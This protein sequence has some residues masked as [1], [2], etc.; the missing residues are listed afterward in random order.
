[1]RIAIITTGDELIRGEI[2]DTNSGWLSGELFDMGIPPALHQTVGDNA[3][4]IRAAITSLSRDFDV[5]VFCGGLGPTPDDLT[6]DA[7]AA[8]LGVDIEVHDESLRRAQAFFESRNM[9]F[10]ENNFRQVRVPSGAE[11]YVNPVGLAPGFAVTLNACRLYFLPGPP[12][13]F[14]ALCR[15]FLLPQLKTMAE[16]Q[17]IATPA[18]RRFIIAGVPESHLMQRA[19]AI[20]EPFPGVQVGDR[21][22]YPEIWLKVLATG[23]DAESVLE[24][25]SRGVRDE[26]GASLVGEGDDTLAGVTGRLLAAR[27]MTLATA[28]SCTGGLVGGMITAVPGSS[29]WYNGGVVT[30]SNELKQHLLG[31]SP[32]LLETHGA[33]SEEVARSMAREA[34]RCCGA[35]IAVAVTGIAGPDGGSAEKPVGLV[36]FALAADDGV[37]HL[38]RVFRPGRGAVRQAAAYT[39]VDMVR[40][41]LLAIG[42]AK[43]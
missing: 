38:R 42:P 43:S 33:V 1:M 32:Q 19:A 3:E 36:H 10:T 5:A 40:R 20:L 13:E 6:V 25:I 17:D 24:T 28:E 18:Y 7:A 35:D 30:Y 34:R 23:P 16:Q 22:A 29:A 8:C 4:D 39:A 31:V 9:A 37:S 11:V 12:R 41:Y 14:E 15:A 2:T 26:F 27:G 21:A